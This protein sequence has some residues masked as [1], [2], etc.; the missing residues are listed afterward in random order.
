MKVPSTEQL[1]PESTSLP[2][3]HP[4]RRRF[5]PRVPGRRKKRILSIALA[6]VVL[7]AVPAGMRVALLFQSQPTYSTAAPRLPGA[8][9]TGPKSLDHERQIARQVDH[10]LSQMTLQEELGQLLVVQFPGTTFDPSLRTMITEQ[11]VGGVI[12]YAG[13]V[14]S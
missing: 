7:A 8:A 9:Y 11:H 3:V 14:Q 6:L 5:P 1:P 12:L 10:L 4:R 2:D 13:N